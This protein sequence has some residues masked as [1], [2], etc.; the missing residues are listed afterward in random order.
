MEKKLTKHG[1]SLALIIDKPLLKLLK[2][3]QQTP[4][5]ISISGD[6]LVITPTKNTKSKKS[7]ILT[8]DT[9]EIAKKIMK[10]T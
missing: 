5:T 2:I 8:K 7:K 10:I 4:I 6:S 9:L 1:N 3:N